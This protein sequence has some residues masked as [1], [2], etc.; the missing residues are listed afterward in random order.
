MSDKNQNIDADGGLWLSISDLATRKGVTKQTIAE[1]VARFEAA[2]RV[3]TRPGKGRTKLVNVA[4]YDRATGDLADFAKAQ[5]AATR[6]N[7]DPDDVAA[8]PAG[9]GGDPVY[10]REQARNMAYTADLKRMDIEE[11]LGRLIPVDRLEAELLRCMVPFMRAIERLERR[12][13]DMAHSV[14]QGGDTAARTWLRH[15]AFEFSNE[16]SAGMGE[17]A[18]ALA[19]E[20]PR[21]LTEFPDTPEEAQRI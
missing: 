11:R 14:R 20:P 3:Q 1:R 12:A 2:G 15:L 6:R 8:P 13:P 21:S 16:I 5:G 4:A 9:A 18:K 7:A 17:L 10:T 19:Q